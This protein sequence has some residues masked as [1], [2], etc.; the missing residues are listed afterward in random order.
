MKRTRW[1][2]LFL[3]VALSLSLALPAFATEE[4]A[5]MQIENYEINVTVSRG[6]INVEFSVDGISKMDKL[7]CES[8][9][10]YKD[11]SS[12]PAGS[13]LEDDFGMSKTDASSHKNTISLPASAGVK[14]TVVVTIFA[15][16]SDG[17]D[18]RQE[19]FSVTGK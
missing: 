11:T 4:R 1:L 19:T 14:Y 17:R 12:T 15:E 3:M 2:S 13:R 10:I 8:I 18:T 5:S 7:G 16:N 6:K 9:Y